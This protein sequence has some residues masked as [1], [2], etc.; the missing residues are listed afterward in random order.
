MEFAS[1]S[2]RVWAAERAPVASYGLL[3]MALV[4]IVFIL[5]LRKTAPYLSYVS[6]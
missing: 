1:L 6:G 2:Q 3:T 5:L 4:L